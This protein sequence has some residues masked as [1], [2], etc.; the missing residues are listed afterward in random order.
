[1]EKVIKK[2][3]DILPGS[4]TPR[5]MNEEDSNMAVPISPRKP[6]IPEA[7]S[8]LD[9]P[10]TDLPK[11]DTN[12]QPP[13]ETSNKLTGWLRSRSKSGLEAPKTSMLNNG[14]STATSTS[15][16]STTSNTGNGLRHSTISSIKPATSEPITITTAG[17]TAPWRRGRP[18]SAKLDFLRK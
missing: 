10:P 15:T 7:I 13:T 1:M 2:Q 11:T 9:N 6:L 3:S 17:N 12:K 16:T 18:S 14:T 4:T 5:K 8:L